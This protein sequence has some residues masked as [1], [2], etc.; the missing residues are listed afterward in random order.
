MLTTQSSQNVQ[1]SQNVAPNFTFVQSAATSF[2]QGQ[3]NI[4]P[5]SYEYRKWF[6][7]K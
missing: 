2:N 3:P 5:P 1:H 6:T 7:I 4:Q